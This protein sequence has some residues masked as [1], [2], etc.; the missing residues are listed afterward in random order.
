MDEL[1]GGEI[2]G[3]TTAGAN[4][5]QRA[6]HRFEHRK[7][8]ALA[9]VR[10]HQAVAGSVKPCQ[11]AL[12][13]LLIEIHDLRRC[14]VGLSRLD[15]LGQGLTLVGRFTAEVLD[16]QTHVVGAT[17]GFQVSLQQQV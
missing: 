9:T 13:Q 1:V 12:G 7:P 10:V 8:K 17:E 15:L 5:G 2:V 14:R 16:H 4:H 11:F 3:G 6:G